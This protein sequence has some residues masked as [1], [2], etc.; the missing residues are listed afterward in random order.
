MRSSMPAS[1]RVSASPSKQATAAICIMPPFCSAGA[2]A[3]CPWLAL[4]TAPPPSPENGEKNMLKTFDQGLAKI[5]SKMGI[6]VV[7]SY[8]GAHLFDS[9]GLND[10]VIHRCLRSTPAPLGGIGF[11]EIE[12]Q[13]RR[14]WQET[15]HPGAPTGAT[16]NV[17]LPDYGWVRFRKADAAEP[18]AW[19]PQRVKVVQSSVGSVRGAVSV[20]EPQTLSRAHRGFRAAPQ[21]LRDML[22][23]R[24][25]G[26][27]LAEDAVEP[28]TEVTRR[29]IASAMSLGSL[30]P[31][32]HGTITEAMNI[33][34]R[35][36]QYRRRRRRSVLSTPD[37]R[38]GGRGLR[39]NKIKQL[40]SGRFG[41]TAEYLA[42]RRRDRD[43]DRAGLEA[44]RR[45]PAPGTQSH[46]ADRAA[47]P[48]TARRHAHQPAAA[49]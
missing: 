2:G 37:P 3:V 41:V 13:V 43:Q 20:A 40:A 19:Q 35:A 15:F 5:M 36:L 7:D 31:E 26:P 16:P 4:Q 48:R 44:R 39:N 49:P 32:A 30:S 18:H 9:I 23:I 22:N 8:R 38:T 46:G 21:M 25:A 34:R 29:F 12:A 10:D 1:A 45:R 33:A 6:S 14:A 28:T 42:Q 27:S 47:A 11:A 24:A 17:D